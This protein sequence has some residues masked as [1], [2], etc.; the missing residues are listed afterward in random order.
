MISD[1]VEKVKRKENLSKEET[2]NAFDE[3]MSGKIRTD[4]LAD[5]LQALA[6]KGEV[7]DELL[8]AVCSMKK[9]VAKVE[10]VIDGELLDIVGTGGDKKSSV[11]VSTASAIVCA[12]AGA[13][14]AKHGNRSVSSSSG[15]ADVLEALGV[16]IELNN[17]QNKKLIEKIGIAFLFARKHHP[18]MKYAAEARQKLG[19]KTIFN[20]IGPLTNPADAKTIVLGVYDEELAKK[21]ANVLAELKLEHALVV[22]G[23]DGFDEISVCSESIVYDIKNDQIETYEISPEQFVLT[24]ADEN[25]LV[26]SGAKDSASKIL[27][28]FN[29]EKNAVR[30]VIL[31]NSG[32]GLYANGKVESIEEGVKLAAECIDSGKT[33]QV[34]DLLISESNK[35][36]IL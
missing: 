31:L 19:I 9:V 6:E 16:N 26:V 20:L 2:I 24:R 35:Y 36:S 28:V 3:I 18:A 10:P 14:I 33:K 1:L 4:E 8:G 25:A 32:A 30:D 5:F 21:F 34:L 11:N 17:K 23:K 27:A 22:H 7:I 29:G 12:S 13:I 15:S